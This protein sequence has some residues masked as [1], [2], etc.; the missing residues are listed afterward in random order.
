VTLAVTAGGSLSA[1]WKFPDGQNLRS[2]PASIASMRMVLNPSPRCLNHTDHGLPAGMH[3]HVLLHA[4]PA[5]AIE[6]VELT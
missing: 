6:C 5:M 2:V 3:V 1:P 4:L